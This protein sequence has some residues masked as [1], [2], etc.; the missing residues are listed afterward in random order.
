MNTEAVTEALAGRSGTKVITN[1]IG[2]TV[3][4][5]WAPFTYKN[6]HWAMVSEVSKEDVES[7]IKG[8]AKIIALIV[9]LVVLV[10]GFVSYLVSG[11]VTRQVSE[12]MKVMVKVGKDNYEDR[13]KITSGDELGA[14]ASSFNEMIGTIQSLL[15]TRQ[16]EH[17]QLQDSIITLLEEI[18][19]LSDGDLS[20]RASVSE[21][22]TG[23]LADSLNLMLEEFGVTIG[24]I[25]KSSEQVGAT[26]SKLSG[27]TDEL[28]QWSDAQSRLIND[29][30]KEINRLTAAIER[31]SELA[32]QSAKTSQFSSQVAGDGAKA[33]EDTSRA[34]ESIRGNVQNTARAIKRLG[35][36]SQEI[37]DF[38]KT[39]NEISDRTSI[40][41]LNASIQAAAAGEEGR[42]F[43]VVA[44]EIQ[45]LAERAAVSTKQIETLIK[46]ILG[47]I[48]EAS[49]SMD[50]S[51]QEVVHGTS[52]SKNALARLD[53]ITKRSTDVA[54]LINGVAAASKEQAAT[55]AK[56]AETMG[57]IGTVS[58]E[59]AKETRQ[60]S[61]EMR[62]MSTMADEMLMSVAT[63]KL[64]SEDQGEVEFVELGSVS[65]ERADVVKDLGI[66]DSK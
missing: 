62:Q 10:V 53:E 45:R 24:K 43:A 31:A 21:D 17:D 18:T 26:A 9:G 12:I 58:L 61:N 49:T 11:G 28:A 30:V 35:E 36:S 39:I 57:E 1:G 34:M 3:L 8:L 29:S 14:M 44:E 37:S 48:T 64:N 60:A 27:S 33:V 65:E 15:R 59:T 7:P 46:N 54:E 13:A 6:L 41:A 66:L 20:V 32:G 56:L 63:F 42:G 50:A 16:Q 23:T 5:S 19:A 22:A 38:A 52:L 25:K 51:I 55:T 47:E 4:A 40:L 2:E